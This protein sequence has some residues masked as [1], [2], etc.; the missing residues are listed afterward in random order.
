[1][2]ANST[3]KT[4][5]M[6]RHVLEV[7]LF[8]NTS[9]KNNELWKVKKR[10]IIA[11]QEPSLLL[12]VFFLARLPVILYLFRK[13]KYLLRFMEAYQLYVGGCCSQKYSESV[14]KKL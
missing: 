14:L 4:N 8:F 9:Y 10:L 11:C 1:M 5:E 13:K 3:Y 12:S 6:Y 7:I 2:I